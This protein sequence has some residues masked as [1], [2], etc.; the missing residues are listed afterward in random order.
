MFDTRLFC[1]YTS[2]Y[3]TLTLICQETVNASMLNALFWSNGNYLHLVF[4]VLKGSAYNAR[5]N[6]GGKGPRH[7]FPLLLPYTARKAR[8]EQVAGQLSAF[9]PLTDFEERLPLNPYYGE[10]KQI[11]GV[12]PRDRARDYA[13][14]QV[15]FPVIHYLIFD[16]DSHDAAIRPV[17]MDL[18]APTLSIITPDTG[19]AHLLYQLFEPI[20]RK[21]E[22][23]KTGNLLA[24]V[25]SGYMVM[26]QAD[27]CITTQLQLVKNPLSD[28][29]DILEGHKPFSLSELVEYIPKRVKRES[30]S[31]IPARRTGIESLAETRERMALEDTA[32]H[33]TPDSRNCV[34]FHNT[35]LYAYSIVAEHS[36]YQSLFKVVLAYVEDLNE[37]QIPDHFS[38]EGKILNFGELRST[39]KSIARFTFKNRANFNKVDRGVMNFQPLEE[40]HL[41]GDEY[42]RE[43]SRRNSLSAERTHGIRREGTR[44]K[45]REGVH[46]CIKHRIDVKADNIATLGRVSRATVYRHMELVR[47]LTQEES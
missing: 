7:F 19:R 20:P 5:N 2:N 17:E 1:V 27:K 29:W 22:S 30:K 14:I 32:Y 38:D 11:D 3:N 9:R 34:L 16:C 39:A 47:E 10:S 26:L 35:R 45:I 44:Q 21:R 15:N 8:N 6:S 37:T 28:R 40:L 46:L 31:E 4:A 23:E 13:Y 18:P 24:D 42:N 43:L 12:L 41:K 33:N 25:I 36:S